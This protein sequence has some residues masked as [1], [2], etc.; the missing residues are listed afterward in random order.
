MDRARE[1]ISYF[2][3]QKRV[4]Y[5]HFTFA[6]DKCEHRCTIPEENKLPTSGKCPKCGHTTKIKQAHF[7]LFLDAK[8]N[9]VDLIKT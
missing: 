1:A 6:C 3:E 8:P 4:A 7:T 2:A 5:V 9:P